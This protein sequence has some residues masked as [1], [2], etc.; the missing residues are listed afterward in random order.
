MIVRE[1]L[2]QVLRA[3]DASINSTST[4]PL[5]DQLELFDR[6]ASD[7]FDEMLLNAIDTKHI[8]LAHA[9]VRLIT[10]F[11]EFGDRMFLISP[12][13]R[14]VEVREELADAVVYTVS[15]LL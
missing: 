1:D 15:G 11:P 9:R 13:E 8:I 2:R 12:E 4:M 10:G 14:L 5:D 7:A 6:V 3:Y